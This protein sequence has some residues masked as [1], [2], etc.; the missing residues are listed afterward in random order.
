MITSLLA[1]LTQIDNIL[2]QNN[3]KADKG[4]LIIDNIWDENG[5]VRFT[6]EHIEE[7]AECSYRKMEIEKQII[8]FYTYDK[9]VKDL[10]K[11]KH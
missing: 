5:N 3:C 6:Q 11:W 1:E 2:A 4:M 9:K 8:D 7:L 10:I